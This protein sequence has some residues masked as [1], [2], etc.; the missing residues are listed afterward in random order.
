MDR[1]TTTQRLRKQFGD[2]NTQ[3][4]TEGKEHPDWPTWVAQQGYSV[5]PDGLIQSKTDQVAE[6]L[7]RRK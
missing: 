3:A 6:A 4:Q 7:I 1:V 5:A 2:S